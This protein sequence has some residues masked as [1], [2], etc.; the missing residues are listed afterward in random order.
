MTQAHYEVKAIEAAKNNINKSL[1]ILNGYQ[2]T[3]QG[4]ASGFLFLQKIKV[5]LCSI[6][7]YQV[8]LL[9]PIPFQCFQRVFHLFSWL[10]C[11]DLLNMGA[12]FIEKS[13]PQTAC[14]HTCTLLFLPKVL[15]DTS[16]CTTGYQLGAGSKKLHLGRF[17]LLRNF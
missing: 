15:S 11:Q 10:G 9:F 13:A 16:R 4:Q 8:L 2:S 1:Y 12:A 7:I 14:I 5:K 6:L 3:D 17:A